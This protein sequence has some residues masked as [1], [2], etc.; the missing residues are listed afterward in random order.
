MWPSRLW[1]CCRS[2]SYGA[3]SCPD[4][5]D[6]RLSKVRQSRNRLLS[7]SLWIKAPRKRGAGGCLF[8]LVMHK[9]TVRFRKADQRTALT[10]FSAGR[11]LIFIDAGS[12]RPPKNPQTEGVR[13]GAS[14][15]G[16]GAGLTPLAALRARVFA[17]V[18]G[19]SSSQ[20]AAE[21]PYAADDRIRHCPIHTKELAVNLRSPSEALISCT[22]DLGDWC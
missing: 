4:R 3:G 16:V 14:K 8:G 1:V 22:P 5:G 10:S 9:S 6:V 20:V 11:G 17:L 15:A 13:G 21:S 12:N 19:P 2:P 7:C 18:N